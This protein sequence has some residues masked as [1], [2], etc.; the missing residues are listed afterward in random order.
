VTELER[1]GPELSTAVVH[2]DEIPARPPTRGE[3]GTTWNTL[4]AELP[5]VAAELAVLAPGFQLVPDGDRAWRHHDA[6]TDLLVRVAA[7]ADGPRTAVGVRIA[8][9]PRHLV[10]QHS[11]LPYKPI[12]VGI[13]LVLSIAMVV[14]LILDGMSLWL[15]PFAL[16]L[17]LLLIPHLLS[18]FVGMAMLLRSGVRD[19][20]RW[21]LNRRWIAAWHRRFWPALTARIAERRP[22]R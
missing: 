13:W 17:A 14:D 9:L 10:V 7:Q 20:R 4:D 18:P 2:A 1:A 8:P 21:R 19:L 5:V 11:T 3:P 6:S 22:Y 16:M 12:F 15:A